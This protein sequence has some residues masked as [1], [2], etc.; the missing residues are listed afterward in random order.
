[1]GTTVLESAGVHDGISVM[2]TVWKCGF[3]VWMVVSL[4]GRVEIMGSFLLL[5]GLTFCIQ[6]NYM[7][8]RV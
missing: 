4:N 3:R 8:T 5:L 2:C 7:S 6:P 1:M